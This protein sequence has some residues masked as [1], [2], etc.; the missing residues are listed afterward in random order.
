MTNTQTLARL[1]IQREKK[2]DYLFGTKGQ[3]KAM[4]KGKNPSAKSRRKPAWI[5][6]SSKI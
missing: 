6:V 2:K 1:H 5:A 4:A 3:N